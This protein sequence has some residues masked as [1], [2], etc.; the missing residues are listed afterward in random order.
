MSLAQTHQRR[1]R[2]E[3]A[4]QEA[5]ATL[6]AQRGMGRFFAQKNWD[7]LNDSLAADLKSLTTVPQGDRR[8]ERKKKLLNVYLP[9]LADYL[10]DDSACYENLVFSWCLVW[11]FDVADWPTAFK[12]AK[13]A[14]TR[15]LHLPTPPFKA[16]Y[17]VANF[18]AD[19]VADFADLAYKNGAESCEVFTA[20]YDHVMLDTQVH[21]VVKMRY[22]K[23]AAKFAERVGDWSKCKELAELAAQICPAKAQVKTLIAKCQKQLAGSPEA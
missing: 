16:D 1:I 7:L 11:A 18:A 17:L 12:L 22:A 13:I 4:K 20:E 14:R 9:E 21:D 10:A 15:D 19:A 8:T 5:Q 23:L 6:A 3:R 2:A